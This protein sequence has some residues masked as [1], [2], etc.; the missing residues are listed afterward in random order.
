M[1]SRPQLAGLIVGLNSLV[2]STVAVAF[3]ALLPNSRANVLPAIV[4]LTLL[5]LLLGALLVVGLAVVPARDD[6]HEPALRLIF[7][8]ALLMAASLHLMLLTEHAEESSLLGLGFVFSGLGQAA[9]ASAVFV[10]PQRLAYY[11]AIGLNVALLFLYVVHVRVGL[12]LV[13]TPLGIAFGRP[14]SVDL[15]GLL[16]IAAEIA[17]V[18]LAIVLLG[19]PSASPKMSTVR[20]QA[21]SASTA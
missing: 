19:D 8:L 17:A 16:T 14:D 21:K 3:P 5:F 12:P 2:L 4:P 15:A 18:V 9:L 6:R 20:Q 13:G 10:R 11:G 1:V 7:W